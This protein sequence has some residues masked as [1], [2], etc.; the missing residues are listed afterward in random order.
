MKELLNNRNRKIFSSI[1]Q[2][3]IINAEP[4]SSRKIAKKYSLDLSSATIRNVMADLEEAGFLSQPHTSAGRIPTD[5]GFRF[6]VNTILNNRELSLVSKEAIKEKYQ[7]FSPEFSVL[8]QETSKILSEFSQGTGVVM[9]PK[10]VDTVFRG[11]E[12][13]FLR[14]NQILAIF[15]SQSGL[16]QKKLIEID[17]QGIS[18]DDLDKYS[19]Y[20]NETFSGF[21]LKEIRYKISK[22]M[23]KEQNRY[24]KLLSRALKM[25]QSVLVNDME[26]EVYIEG[27]ANFLNYP[28]FAEVEKMKT[29]FKTFNEKTVLL[30]ILDKAMENTGL[31]IFI[32]AENQLPELENCSFILASYSSRNRNVLGALGVV[33]PTRMNYYYIIPVVDYIAKFL[34]NY[35]DE[36][37]LWR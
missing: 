29:I 16:M 28:E 30:T 26:V 24:N 11:I 18:Q 23:E 5:Q 34:S 19:R 6:Y 32:G 8:M 36:E 10:I 27:Q 33:G 37:Q 35:L 13:V 17:D 14:K 20:L 15:V 31:Q 2:E 3:Y 25:G 22:E 21:T 12:F 1:V 9:A 7:K 4:V